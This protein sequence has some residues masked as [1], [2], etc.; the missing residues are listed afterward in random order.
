MILAILCV[1][2]VIGFG[3]ALYIF[4]FGHD[5]WY[6]FLINTMFGPF[7]LGWAAITSLI[8]LRKIKD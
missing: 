5:K 4:L 2:L 7:V 6:L 3:Y 8:E 1:Y